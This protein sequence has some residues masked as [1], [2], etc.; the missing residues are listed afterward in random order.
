MQYGGLFN[1]WARDFDQG[2]WIPYWSQD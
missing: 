1:R 2:S